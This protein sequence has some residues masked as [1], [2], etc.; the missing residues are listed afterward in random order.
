MSSNEGGSI[1]GKPDLTFPVSTNGID[2]EFVDQI[3]ATSELRTTIRAFLA[4]EIVP[5]IFLK[6]AGF[7]EF[8]GGCTSFN[9]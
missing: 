7:D 3:K 9:F 5:S 6:R 1:S 2:E 4:N 8:L